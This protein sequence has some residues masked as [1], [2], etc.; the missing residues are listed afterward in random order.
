MNAYEWGIKLKSCKLALELRKQYDSQ[1]EW[2]KACNRSDWL[3]WQLD[4]LPNNK[5]PIDKAHEILIKIV[6]RTITNN[7]L[8]CGS[9]NVE[10]W[11]VDW[12]NGTNRSR[13]E[14]HTS[15]LQS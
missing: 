7:A 6:T 11:A 5:Y 15:E 10:Q 12:L 8:H 2:W 3:L 14:E 9:A 13:S 4:Q 1:K